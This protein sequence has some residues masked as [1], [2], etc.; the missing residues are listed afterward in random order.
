MTVA[1]SRKRGTGANDVRNNR[2]DWTLLL[3]ASAVWPIDE[4]LVLGGSEAMAQS[5]LD[6]GL[7][8]SWRRPRGPHD[9]NTLVVAWDDC[10]LAVGQIAGHV[11]PGGLLYMEV[12]RRH[13]GRRLLGPRSVQ[14]DL[15]RSG[16]RLVSAHIVTPDFADPRRYLPIDHAQ[17]VR[18][19]LRALFM[20]G[21]PIMRALRGGLVGVLA[22]PIAGPVLRL[23]MLRYTVIATAA[24]DHSPPLGVPMA[25]GD[26]RVIVVTSGYDQGSRAVVLPFGPGDP[27]P[28]FAVKVASTSKTA[29]ATLREH[30][31]LV[32][33]HATLPARTARALPRPIAVYSLANRTACVQSCAPGPSMNATVGLWGRPFS[34]KIRD[35]DVVVDWLTEFACATRV[36]VS[37]AERN[38]A[39]IYDEVAA[40]MQ[41][42]SEVVDFL[43]EA[44]AIARSTNLARVAVHQHYDVGP[45]NVHIDGTT[46]MLLDWE[47]DDLRPADCLGPPLG[48]VLYLI[49][50]WY[51][52]TSN[53]KSEDAEEEAIV[54]LF[55]T[56]AA[57]DSY[58]VAARTAINRALV[59]FGLDRSVI[60][61]VLAAVWA[62][63]ALYTSR[64]RA[65]LGTPIE[66]GRSR[67]EA[68]L[69]TLA[70]VMPTMCDIMVGDHAAWV[71]PRP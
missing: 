49:I 11:A 60:P 66:V 67:P 32:Q 23:V 46:P 3:P 65:A 33:L 58:V 42:P 44:Q 53:T 59:P 21:T 10:P 30:E 26:E 27:T 5:L 9:R 12:D 18:W 19:H 48:D 1:A 68:F 16:C 17:A 55:A 52:L 38:W 29:T 62:E 70:R 39:L 13:P 50:Y 41:L 6:H 61:A 22:T 28:R 7:A 37:V 47:T 63:R 57:P 64:R 51:F 34:A 36:D 71:E 4:V 69:R 54:R 8:R 24:D 15:A 56:A 14:R 43:S 40:I 2:L 25:R 31:R 45:W 35:L 20:A